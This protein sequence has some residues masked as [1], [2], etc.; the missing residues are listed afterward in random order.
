MS[1]DFAHSSAVPSG[2]FHGRLG[3][4]PQAAPPA[5][6]TASTRLTFA[7]D[8]ARLASLQ[9]S[10][11]AVRERIERELGAEDAAYIARI[12]KLSRR[13]EQ[14]GRILIHVSFDPVTFAVGVTAL[15]GHKLLEL[16]EI[17]HMALHGAYDKIDAPKRFHSKTFAWKAPIDEDAWRVGHNVRHHQ[18]TNVAGR[19]P[20]L[21]F[22]GLRLSDGI[23]Y[24][25]VHRLQPL[26]NL[27]SWMAFANAIN[28]HVTGLLEVYL[29]QGEPPVLKDRSW[30]SLRDAHRKF[31]RKYVRYHAREYLLF[32]LL[33]GPFFAKTLLGNVLSEITRDVFAGAVI[34]C[35][36][37]GVPAFP[38]G[39]RAGSRAAW[40]EMQ[41]QAAANLDLPPWLS[42][43]AGGL[44]KQIEHH[45]FP[46]LPPNRLRQV[47]AEVQGICEAH[48]VHYAHGKWPERLKLVLRTLR[49]LSL[50]HV[51]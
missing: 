28:L 2:Q 9:R 14:A 25:S 18:Y 4:R 34:Y 36:H 3:R 30:A 12:G 5:T 7:D 33:A 10:L 8:E 51:A 40:Y 50:P 43:L 39:A 26:S 42:L 13:L 21:D 38:A 44:D 29:G 35:G 32:P 46:R 31:L 23:A 15:S 6:N 27:V 47:A 19:D 24:K 41:I 49:E 1:M 45:L 22:G 16:T 11:D 37:V 17:G 20:D 48:G